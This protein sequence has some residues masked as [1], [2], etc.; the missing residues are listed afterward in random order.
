MQMYVQDAERPDLRPFAKM[1]Q[2]D[3]RGYAFGKVFP[4]I[5]VR[6][7]GGKIYVAGKNLTNGQGTKGRSDG[8]SLS[9][10][11][12][13][14]VEVSY[15]TGRVEG[16]GKIYEH[17]MH[18]YSSQEAAEQNG[19][20]LA[21]R[22]VLNTVEKDAMAVIFSSARISGATSGTAKGILKELH[23]AAKSVRA[24]G[25]PWLVC[26]DQAFLDLCGL[27][28]IEDRLATATKAS[29]DIGF[30]A[31][32]DEKVLQTISTLLY[33]N[34]IAVYDSDIVGDTYDGYVAVVAVQPETIGASSDQVLT[35]A[36]TKA[37]AGATIVCLPEDAP[38]G[39]PFTL[40]TAADRDNKCNLF[41]AEGWLQIKEFKGW[42]VNGT[43]GALE[44]NGGAV[45][46]SI[47]EE[48]ED[49]AEP[50]SEA[51]GDGQT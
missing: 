21:G 16:R 50:A 30:M 10:T 41:D 29:G 31:L 36:K 15:S 26:S 42:T 37:M 48:T 2:E 22:L 3:M 6:G 8:T 9:G 7:K 14:T 1:T 45:L 38:A 24:Y 5:F 27:S 19:A 51:A 25:K 47:P 20:T 44:D 46:I 40:S 4:V 12:L 28:K 49:E 43:S 18:G 32:Q 39:E 11:A 23:N 17:E 33:F 13:A 35:V 34:G